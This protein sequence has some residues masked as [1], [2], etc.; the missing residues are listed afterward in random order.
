MSTVGFFSNIISTLIGEHMFLT[1]LNNVM[2]TILQ[3]TLVYTGNHDFEFGLA[4][5]V[6]PL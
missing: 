6:T 4:P 5:M 2:S 1:T 3:K